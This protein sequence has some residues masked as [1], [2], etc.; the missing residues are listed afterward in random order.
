MLRSKLFPFAGSNL[1]LPETGVGPVN[2]AAAFTVNNQWQRLK[3]AG[4]LDAPRP[5][6]GAVALFVD[7]LGVFHLA[8]GMGG[9]YHYGAYNRQE[10]EIFIAPLLSPQLVQGRL[11]RWS[12]MCGRDLLQIGDI[13]LN[14]DCTEMEGMPATA[15]L[16]VTVRKS[17][18]DMI[19]MRNVAD[20]QQWGAAAVM[21]R[22]EEPQKSGERQYYAS[23]PKFDED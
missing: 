15:V 17:I 13:L 11:C 16:K 10:L 14:N 1:M 2:G 18:Y 21:K 7:R 22:R 6:T 20:V 23:L 19:W 3:Q 9:E 12:S 4:N 5:F 8:Y